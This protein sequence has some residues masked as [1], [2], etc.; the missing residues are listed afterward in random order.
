MSLN[1]LISYINFSNANNIDALYCKFNNVTCSLLHFFN[2]HCNVVKASEDIASLIFQLTCAF[3][4]DSVMT[5]APYLYTT[6]S[7]KRKAIS[8]CAWKNTLCVWPRLSL[9]AVFVGWSRPGRCQQCSRSS[10]ESSRGGAVWASH[11][12]VVCG[13][14]GGG[15]GQYDPEAST[16]KGH[17]TSVLIAQPCVTPYGS[18]F[19]H[20]GLFTIKWSD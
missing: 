15:A 18:L 17:V 1:L 10:K 8:A 5:W 20:K 9:L 12:A 16:G 11:T 4:T 7:N 2:V 13:R 14:D 19:M 6:V 3:I